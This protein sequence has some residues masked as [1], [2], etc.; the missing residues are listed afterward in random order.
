MIEGIRESHGRL[1]SLVSVGSGMWRIVYWSGA[2]VCVEEL[3]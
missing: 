2:E 1:V 3:T